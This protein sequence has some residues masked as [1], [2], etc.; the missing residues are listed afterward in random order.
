MYQL[1]DSLAKIFEHA[2]KGWL[3]LNLMAIAL[4]VLSVL[5]AFVHTGN[6]PLLSR[7]IAR[8]KRSKVKVDRA[9]PVLSSESHSM[10]A[11]RIHERQHPVAMAST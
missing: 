5:L 7:F 10:Q 3:V 4:L 11:R 8:L 1:S 9:D 2:A 6:Q